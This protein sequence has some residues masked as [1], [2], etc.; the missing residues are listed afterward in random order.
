M[1]FDRESYRRHPTITWNFGRKE[2]FG[3]KE[4]PSLPSC[5]LCAI[6]IVEDWINEDRPTRRE[7]D[8]EQELWKT[9]DDSAKKHVLVPSAKVEKTIFHKHPQIWKALYRGSGYF[10]EKLGIFILLTRPSSGGTGST[11]SPH[12]HHSLR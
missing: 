1:V 7:I 8:E 4:V 2:K 10:P 5:L 9:Y 6:P 11:A 12:R 3:R